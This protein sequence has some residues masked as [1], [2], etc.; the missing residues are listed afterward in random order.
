MLWSPLHSVV[1]VEP[2]PKEPQ[3]SLV[4]QS[5]QSTISTLRNLA[6]AIE[7]GEIDNYEVSQSSDGAV[8]IKVDQ[9]NKRVIQNHQQIEG[10]SC[11]ENEFVEKRPIKERRKV[12][13]GL[14]LEGMTQQ[15]IAE[16]TMVSQ[17]TISNDI[18]ALRRRGKLE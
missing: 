8:R 11:V 5:K 18:A 13:E 9:G 4:T 15:E 17:K 1:E 2:M 7:A 10:Y 12:V 14:A 3:H 16:R 6:N